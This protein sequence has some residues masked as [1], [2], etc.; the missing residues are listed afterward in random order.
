[1]C[2]RLSRV[3]NGT[4]NW[5]EFDLPDV[6]EVW[7]EFNDETAR[8]KYFTE[9]IFEDDWLEIINEYAD[10]PV[11]FTAEGLF[12]YFS[13][14]EVAQLLKKFSLHFPN[15]E[16]IA[17]V[18]SKIA[19]KRRHP[20][21]KKTSLDKFKEPWGVVNGREFEKWNVGV[22]HIHDDFIT[23]NGNA[24]KRMPVLNKGM[25]QLPF[26]RKVGKMVHLKFEGN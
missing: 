15:S 7:L 9:S 5:L 19:L 18:Y 13:I 25:A 8:H 6:K 20:D 3:D 26:F 24:M 17:E 23:S 2:T 21:V 22:K 16:L 1:M 12:M 4:I 11:M 14:E 10:G